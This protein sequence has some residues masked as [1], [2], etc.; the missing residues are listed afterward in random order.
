MTNPLNNSHLEWLCVL[1]VGLQGRLISTYLV[2]IIVSVQLASLDLIPQ[3]GVLC[4]ET[5]VVVLNACLLPFLQQ[6][7]HKMKVFTNCFS[8]LLIPN[9]TSLVENENM[10]WSLFFV[11]SLREVVPLAVGTDVVLPR[12]S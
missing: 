7:I 3:R 11:D 2:L 5:E 4:V 9:H 10:H 8:F 6:M 1:Y 12:L